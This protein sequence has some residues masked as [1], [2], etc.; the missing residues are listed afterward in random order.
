MPTR[1]EIV[2]RLEPILILLS[3][4]V[5]DDPAFE[6]VVTK[7]DEY[8][9]AADPRAQGEAAHVLHLLLAKR[10]AES[11]R[12]ILD[13]ETNQSPMIEAGT[14]FDHHR[15]LLHA[16]PARVGTI[17]PDH[18]LINEFQAA[19]GQRAQSNL[20]GIGHTE[21]GIESHAIAQINESVR[22]IL[23]CV[24]YLVDTKTDMQE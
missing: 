22:H 23:Q 4:V 3:E 14:S 19:G 10:A 24:D 6:A 21:L 9:R 7:I 17:Y 18:A 12:R 13:I 8:S 2:R 15:K 5:A 20:P 16:L 11:A 1:E